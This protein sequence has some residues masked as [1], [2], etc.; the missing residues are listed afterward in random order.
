MPGE[1][2]VQCPVC[3]AKQTP[4]PECRRCRADLSL[5]CK[6]IQSHSAVR[7]QYLLAR[8]AGDLDQLASALKY[9]QWL[10]PRDAGCGP[11]ETQRS[12]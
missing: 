3:R 5:Y 11:Q 2:E 6:A 4:K 1:I 12:F 10:Q 8:Q 9:W 7:R